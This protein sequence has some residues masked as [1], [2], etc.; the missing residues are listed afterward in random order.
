MNDMR[1]IIQYELRQALTGLMPPPL[2]T[3]PI[4]LIIPSTA[5]APPAATV[6]I[7]IAIPPVVIVLPTAILT[8]DIKG[9]PSNSVK[10]M[11]TVQ[12]KKKKVRNA[13][14]KNYQTGGTQQESIS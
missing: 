14:K 6:Y 1:A 13:R 3:I 7:T 10:V 11:P 2:A 12:M 4:A 9:K 5:D 8:D